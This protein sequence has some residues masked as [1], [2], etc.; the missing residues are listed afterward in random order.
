MVFVI[1]FFCIRLLFGIGQ[2]DEQIPES[3]QS[4][5]FIRNF[6]V[7]NFYLETWRPFLAH[8]FSVAFS[9]TSFFE[10]SHEKRGRGIQRKCKEYCDSL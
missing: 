10:T 9:M 6:F 4:I 8:N 1:F 7:I 3:A 2:R 5:F